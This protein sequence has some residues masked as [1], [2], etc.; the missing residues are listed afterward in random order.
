MK[1]LFNKHASARRLGM[2]LAGGAALML[3]HGAA[4][5]GIATSKHDLTPT[6][7]ANKFAPTAAG[8]SEICVFCHTPHG[9]NI[10]A[11]VPLWNRVLGD[12]TT[13]TSYSA[14]GTS[15]L[16][17]GTMAVG[18]VSLACLSCHDGTQAM[19]TVINAPGSGG[20]NATGAA[21]AGTWTNGT[22]KA[23]DASPVGSLSNAGIA[24]LTKDLRDDHP[25]GIQYGGGKGSAY[26][27]GTAVAAGGNTDPDFN[28]LAVVPDKALWYV[29]TN[30]TAGRQKTD[31][32]LYTRDGT[33]VTGPTGVQ[34]FVECATCHDPHS[35]GGTAP[36]TFL[37]TTNEGSKLCLACHNK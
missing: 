37:R 17:G 4:M 34:P 30:A 10:S 14:L 36:P 26:V 23:A 32:I 21:M 31:L 3:M 7:S 9:A 12:P 5:A 25:V 2:L 6:G 28:A 13:Y 35:A 33:G 11:V 27:A 19:N 1:T 8:T 29:D 20:Y 15:S 24:N 18:S 16:D 22:G